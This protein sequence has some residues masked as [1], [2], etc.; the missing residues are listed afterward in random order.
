[1]IFDLF[2]PDEAKAVTPETEDQAEVEEEVSEISTSESTV[3]GLVCML[4]KRRAV[5][6]HDSVVTA[7][8]SE[9]LEKELESV[10]DVLEECKDK[11]SIRVEIEQ[12]LRLR[13]RR[14]CIEMA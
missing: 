14:E 9:S 7:Q 4:G 6:D 5:D 11:P 2:Q 8:A 1:M 10:K 12:A 13:T 3:D